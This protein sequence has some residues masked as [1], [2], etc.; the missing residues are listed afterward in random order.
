[1]TT[2][3]DFRRLAETYGGDLRRW[4][5][6]ARATAAAFLEASPDAAASILAPEQ[7]LEV[8]LDA[9]DI[10]VA[11]ALRDRI[12]AAAPRARVAGRLGRWAAATA[13]GLGLAGSCAAG[14]AAG[15]ALAPPSVTHLF[16]GEPTPS[17]SQSAL[18][19]PTGDAGT[20]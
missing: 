8:Q 1:M 6:A 14:V 20:G 7:A 5:S 19:D 4:P 3:Q 18:A 10:V 11:P 9:Y 13:L 17:A 2:L 15:F 16:I 12:L